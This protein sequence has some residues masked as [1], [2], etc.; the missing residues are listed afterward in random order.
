MSVCGIKLFGSDGTDNTPSSNPFGFRLIFR[1]D[2]G[3]GRPGA[4]LA[5][6]G[7]VA[8]TSFADTGF[9][10]AGLDIYE[11][12]F[13]FIAPVALPS[14]PI[15]I[16]EYESTSSDVYTVAIDP[17]P[18]IAAFLDPDLVTWNPTSLNIGLVVYANAVAA[19]P[20]PSPTASA[21]P[22]PNAAHDWVVFE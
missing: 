15:W 9:D 3:T 12:C 18:V 5:D 2:D 20:S 22:T 14:G 1:A 19:T 10:E 16:E 6:L 8:P 17:T 11:F 21:S 4:V 7:V 13:Q